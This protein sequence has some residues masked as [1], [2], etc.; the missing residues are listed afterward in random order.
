MVIAD[1][2]ISTDNPSFNAMTVTV[3][4]DPIG[5]ELLA[6]SEGEINQEWIDFSCNEY[7]PG[8]I[9]IATITVNLDQDE[10]E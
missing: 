9:I 8:S 7:K 6:C 4:S 5:L 1:V 3:T 2:E 10:T